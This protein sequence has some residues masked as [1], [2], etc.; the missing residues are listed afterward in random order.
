[1]PPE[2]VSLDLERK[3]R[4]LLALLKGR[5]VAT[6]RTKKSIKS[7]PKYKQDR[8]LKTRRK[9]AKLAAAQ[10]KGR[11]RAKTKRQKRNGRK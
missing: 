5:P 7:R 3:V 4:R 11:N 1:M 2:R 8:A 10:K 6:H 9:K